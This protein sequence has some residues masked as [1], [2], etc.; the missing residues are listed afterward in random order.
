MGLFLP[1]Q[2]KALRKQSRV[3]LEASYH[4]YHHVLEIGV[5]AGSPVRTQKTGAPRSDRFLLGRLPC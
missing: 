1:S 5:F 2:A 3:A 4:F